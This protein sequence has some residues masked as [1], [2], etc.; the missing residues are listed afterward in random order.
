V[1]S[2]RD[3]TVIR[4]QQSLGE[5]QRITNA[6]ADCFMQLPGEG[7]VDEGR[8]RDPSCDAALLTGYMWHGEVRER[9]V[10]PF[11]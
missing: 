10:E 3:S 1:A 8:M 4:V 9:V 11:L 2:A 6:Q 7:E 5:R